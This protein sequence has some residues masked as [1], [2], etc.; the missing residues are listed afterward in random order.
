MSDA[1]KRLRVAHA[2]LLSMAETFESAV[3][4]YES[5]GKGGQHVPYHGDFAQL[6]PSAVSQM[7]RWARDLREAI[8]GSWPMVDEYPCHVCGEKGCGGLC[9]LEAP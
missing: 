4:N 2:A 7:R 1:D 6:P 5:R 3:A 8:K 9:V